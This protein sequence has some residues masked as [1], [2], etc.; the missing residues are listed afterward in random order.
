MKR[1]DRINNKIAEYMSLY[2]EKRHPNLVEEVRPMTSD[3]KTSI[4]S[5]VVKGT[6]GSYKYYSL[7]ISGKRFV[8]DEMTALAL[9]KTAE[10]VVTTFSN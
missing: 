3:K 4:V 9:N 10:E 8:I 5:G 6:N 1:L 2:F 7:G